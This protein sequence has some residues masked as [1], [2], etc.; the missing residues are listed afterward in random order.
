MKIFDLHCDT[1]MRFYLGQRLR[2][3]HGG[4]ISLE[5]LRQGDWLCQCF[6][7]FVPWG[8]EKPRPGIPK[9]P[10]EY[11][12]LAYAAWR[13]ELAD[14]AGELSPA[15]TVDEILENDAAGRLSGMLTVEDC[16]TLDGRIEAV[17]EYYALGVRMAALTWNH[18]NSLG[19]PNSPDPERHALPLKPFGREAVARMNA[20]GIAVDVSHLSEGG[21]WDVA[22]LSRAPFV[23]SHSC[24]RALCDVPRNLTDAQLRAIGDAGGIV[25]VNYYARFLRPDAAAEDCPSRIEDVVR[26]VRYMVG[27]AG[28]DAVGLG[29]DYDGM[30]SPLEWGDAG[31]QQRLVRALEPWFST[32]ELEKLCWKNAVRVFRDVESCKI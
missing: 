32:E 18:E 3:D 2:D 16:V 29:S 23:A 22:R 17:D 13:R 6:A 12:R 14:C 20:L 27:H 10:K 4:H 5:K 19:Y 26:H 8:N 7:I 28:I 9:D 21:F 11:F 24:A 25:G 30:G 1:I 15:R 31:G